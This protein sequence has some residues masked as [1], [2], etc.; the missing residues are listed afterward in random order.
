VRVD[1]DRAQQA[2]TSFLISSLIT[3][4]CTTI[5]EQNSMHNQQKC[6]LNWHTNAI[7]HWMCTQ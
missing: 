7:L 3:W 4:M 5:K 1:I 6:H 2:S